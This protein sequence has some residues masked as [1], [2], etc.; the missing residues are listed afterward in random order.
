VVLAF[1]GDL[2]ISNLLKTEVNKQQHG[3]SEDYEPGEKVSG[4]SKKETAQTSQYRKRLAGSYEAD[5]D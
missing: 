3:D 1:A 2:A 4:C 5:G